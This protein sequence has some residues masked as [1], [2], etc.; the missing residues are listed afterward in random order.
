MIQ[1]HGHD[2]I[3]G[4]VLDRSGYAPQ[5]QLMKHGA[6]E[7]PE[8]PRLQQG[9]ADVRPSLCFEVSVSKVRTEG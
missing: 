7:K 3:R 6:C 9:M 1:Q 8:S 5:A 4:T 2:H